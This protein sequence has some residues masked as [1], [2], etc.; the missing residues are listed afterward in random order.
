MVDIPE[1]YKLYSQPCQLLGQVVNVHSRDLDLTI[2]AAAA[3]NRYETLLKAAARALAWHEMDEGLL[4][5][6]DAEQA[7]KDSPLNVEEL[8]YGP[9]RKVLE[10]CKDLYGWK[11]NA[12]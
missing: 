9:L 7:S 8:I 12:T 3:L 4:D 10:E 6:L 2:K 11:A 5:E 1:R